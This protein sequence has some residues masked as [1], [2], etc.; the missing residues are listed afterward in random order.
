MTIRN[1]KMLL[2][3]LD[4]GR[5][6]IGGI[7]ADELVAMKRKWRLQAEDVDCMFS[8]LASDLEEAR[9]A[10]ENQDIVDADFLGIE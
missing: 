4:H 5:G 8:N 10:Q 2:E 9:K 1:A 7:G 6:E 3:G